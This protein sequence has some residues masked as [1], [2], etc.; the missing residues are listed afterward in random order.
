[1]RLIKRPKH[2]WADLFKTVGLVAGIA[3][4]GGGLLFLLSWYE[5][6]MWSECRAQHSWFFCV[7]VLYPSHDSPSPS[8]R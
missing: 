1:M 4:L 5:Y 6:A 7:R 8:K 2:G 3:L